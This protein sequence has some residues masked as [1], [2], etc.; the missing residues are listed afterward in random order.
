LQQ[1]GNYCPKDFQ[2]AKPR[3]WPVVGFDLG[4]KDRSGGVT[5][6]WSYGWVIQFASNYHKICKIATYRAIG[7]A[8]VWKQSRIPT[9]AK[10]SLKSAVWGLAD[11]FQLGAIRALG[12]VFTSRRV[13]QSKRG[14]GCVDTTLR[15]TVEETTA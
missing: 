9:H 6:G 8:H 11:L 7:A 12:Y 10:V 3:F 15:K 1:S 14:L 4:N 2:Q 13:I 5:F